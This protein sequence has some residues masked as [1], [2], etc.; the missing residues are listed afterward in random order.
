M[1]WVKS[2][3]FRV[4]FV[5]KEGDV[6]NGLESYHGIFNKRLGKLSKNFQFITKILLE[7]FFHPQAWQSRHE[8][9]DVIYSLIL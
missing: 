1:K 9:D 2:A 6:Q 7:T 5:S 8:H 3:W 4:I